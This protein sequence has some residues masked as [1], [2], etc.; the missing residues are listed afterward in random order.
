MER[1]PTGRVRRE[2]RRLETARLQGRSGSIWS[3]SRRLHYYLGLYFIF[4]IWLFSVSGLVLNHGKW[5]FADFWADREET[6]VTRPIVAPVATADLEA[7]RELMRQLGLVGE[8][9]RTERSPDGAEFRIQVARPGRTFDVEADLAAGRAEVKE[10]RVNVWGVMS[11]LHH[12]T[13]VSISD[14]ERERDWWLTRV[15]S[16]AM[17]AVALGLV[18]LVASGIYLWY[19]LPR[20]RR[21]GA[22]ALAAGVICC[23]W[24]VFGLSALP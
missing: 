19:H 5:P 8:V 10:I 24:F 21:L 15:W 13:G 6:T 1:R 11:A 2:T 22:L 18:F 3:W 17:D 20:K 14:P 9:N 7:A 16:L 12:F 4:F 23:A